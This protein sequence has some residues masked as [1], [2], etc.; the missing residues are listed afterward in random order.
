MRAWTDLPQIMLTKK[1]VEKTKQ[2]VEATCN[3]VGRN[4]LQKGIGR[5]INGIKIALLCSKHDDDGDKSEAEDNIFH[6]SQKF[7]SSE[8]IAYTC[9]SDKHIDQLE[10]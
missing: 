10:W 4:V 6:I 8:E 7:E 1:D 5:F 9:L 2:V 3:I